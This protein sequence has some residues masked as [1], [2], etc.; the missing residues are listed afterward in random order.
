MRFI[1]VS[2]KNTKEKIIVVWIMAKKPR[3]ERVSV[4]A[5]AMMGRGKWSTKDHEI[6]ARWLK[7]RREKEERCFTA[8]PMGQW[9]NENQRKTLPRRTLLLNLKCYKYLDLK[10]FLSRETPGIIASSI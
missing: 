8:G 6:L 4:V 3:Y 10:I 2:D 1:P 9:I 7:L 5:V